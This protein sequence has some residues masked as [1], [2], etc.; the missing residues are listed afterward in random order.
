MAKSADPTQPTPA[1]LGYS[2]P[3]EWE[4]HEATWLGW[5]HHPTDW[6]GKLDTIRWVYGEMVRKISPGDGVRI[7]VSSRAEEKLARR[8]LTRAGAALDSVEIGVAGHD[9]TIDRDLPAQ[10]DHSDVEVVRAGTQADL[11]AVDRDRVVGRLERRDTAAAITHITLAN[12]RRTRP[13]CVPHP[14]SPSGPH[15]LSP[16]PCRERGDSG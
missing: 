7:L 15:P 4:P 14:L 12:L 5:P 13:R 8:Y 11:V 9:L 16:S 3:A 6:P 2:M 10:R 1:E